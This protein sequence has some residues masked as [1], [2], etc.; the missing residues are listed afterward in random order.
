MDRDELLFA[1][2]DYLEEADDD[3]LQD[4]LEFLEFR[5][6]QTGEEGEEEEE[7]EEEEEEEEIEEESEEILDKALSTAVPIGSPQH[8]DL[9]R[10]V[11]KQRLPPMPVL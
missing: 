4:V 5:L 9:L 10:R 2:D 1:I 6:S 11:R 3:V 7:T 8:K